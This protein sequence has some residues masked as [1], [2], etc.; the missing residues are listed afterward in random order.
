MTLGMSMPVA[1]ILEA[2]FRWLACLIYFRPLEWRRNAIPR[3]MGMFLIGI[4]LDAAFLTL[5]ETQIYYVIVS[6]SILLYA[7]LM[8]MFCT[9]E[10]LSIIVYFSVWAMLTY[11]WVSE[12]WWLLHYGEMPWFAN[13]TKR[14]LLVWFAVVLAVYVILWFTVAIWMPVYKAE[15]VGP[16][17]L[18]STVLLY[19]VFMLLTS[20]F[21]QDGVMVSLGL[22]SI[23]AFMAQFYCITVMYLQTALFKNSAIQ[24]ELDTMN[25]LWNQQ[26]QQYE[27]AKENIAIINQ[28]CHDLKHQLAAMRTMENSSQREKYIKEIQDSVNIYDAMVKTGNETLDT[29]LTEKRLICEANH[30]TINCV[31]DGGSLSF[32]D[33]V[34][35]YTVMGN[36]LDNAMEAVQAFHKQELRVID[37][38]IHVRQKFLVI[39][40]SNPMQGEL[41][42]M[43]GLPVSTKPRNG[44]HGF[45]IQSIRST[46]H[47]Y[48]GEVTVEAKDGY[49]SL[50]MLMPIKENEALK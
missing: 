25:I 12:F 48:G 44:Y 32:M 9:H 24:H 35:I 40:V 15:R 5:K 6:I 13:E 29:V 36:A 41:E 21:Y 30:I 27:R 43:G 11:F 33:P 20:G 14:Q 38:L 3:V 37:V 39:S 31:A 26:Q 10:S 42:F 45:G 1:V 16:R 23:L 7:V 17:Q 22:T 8:G 46:F 47:K 4:L 28:K 50:C 49:F 19:G 18:I 2:T 34:D